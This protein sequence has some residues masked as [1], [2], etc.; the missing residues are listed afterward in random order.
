MPS[1]VLQL[2]PAEAQAHRQKRRSL[3]GLVGVC[4]RVITATPRVRQRV[5][6]RVAIL[7]P[8]HLVLVLFVGLGATRER[9]VRLGNNPRQVTRVGWG[10]LTDLHVQ[11]VVVLGRQVV[12]FVHYG[13]LVVARFV[14]PAQPP[15]A[16]LHRV[17]RKVMDI[18][19]PRSSA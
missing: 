12:V 1:K 2:E 5:E 10:A 17:V 6:D 7:T 13:C 8:I 11:L 16:A 3:A 14:R 4:S 19:C 18:L 15:A 9:S